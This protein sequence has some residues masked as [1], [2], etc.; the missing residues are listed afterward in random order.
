[1]AELATAQHLEITPEELAMHTYDS[2]PA[3]DHFLEQDPDLQSS[4]T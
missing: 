1:M 4:P 2:K 3:T